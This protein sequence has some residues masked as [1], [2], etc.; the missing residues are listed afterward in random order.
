ML[1]STCSFRA[2]ATVLALAALAACSSKDDAAPTVILPPTGVSWTVDGTGEK[3]SAG[4]NSVSAN[5][6]EFTT[7]YSVTATSGGSIS[8]IVPAVIGTYGVSIASNTTQA[9]YQY[10]GTG[11]AQV[12]LGT[13]GTITVTNVTATKASGT[14]SF[15][16][17][18]AASSTAPLRSITNGVFNLEL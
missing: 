10:K 17:R 1:L 5:T 2:V 13:S 11:S 3:A 8:I 16:A 4:Q 18:N 14:F 12:Y 15:M 6:L 9:I 7:A